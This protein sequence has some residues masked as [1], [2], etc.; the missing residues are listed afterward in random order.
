MNRP[1]R[2]W[3]LCLLLT[4]PTVGRADYL[5]AP[6]IED[7]PPPTDQWQINFYAENDS[8]IFKPNSPADRHYTNGIGLSFARRGGAAS[9]WADDFPGAEAFGPARVASGFVLGQ[10]MFTPEDISTTAL[11]PDDRP[12]AGYL[13]LGLF[14]QRA[15]ERTLEHYQMELGVVGPLSF[16]EDAQKW[17]HDGTGAPDPVGWDN[18][19]GDEVTF[20][21]HYRRKWRSDPPRPDQAFQTQWVPQVAAALGTVHRFIEGGVLWRAGQNLP[22]DFGP[23]HLQDVAS[24]TG[25]PV[26]GFG[27]SVFA[28]GAVRLV[29]H[30]MFLEGNNFKESH[31]VRPEPILGLL[32]AGFAL[33]HQAFNS[34]VEFGYS[35]T[36]MTKEFKGQND[37]HAYGGIFLSILHRF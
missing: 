7:P 16:A 10:L 29:E 23:G 3:L 20:Q 22:D 36:F 11:V 30:N 24:A 35:Q 27:W 9:E 21:T 34:Q 12:Y 13:F 6:K 14:F 8:R 32:R 18:Q 33:R 37:G 4:V 1:I 5:A 26:E 17:V 15:R 25:D 31:G 28:H 2:H 19:L